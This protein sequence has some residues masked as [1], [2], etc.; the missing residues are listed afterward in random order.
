MGHIL[1]V[2]PVFKE[3]IWGG[4]QL[5]EKYGY[6]I[7]SDQTGEC[8]APSAHPNGDNTIK[9]GEFKG[10]TLSK[11]FD[12]HREL[13]GNIKDKQFPLLVKI[14]DA[15]NDLS[16]QVHPNDEYAAVHENGSLG[17]TECWYI[18]DCKEDANI[19]IGHHAKDKKELADM[20]HE[21]RWNELIRTIPIKGKGI[22]SRLIQVVFMLLKVEH[23]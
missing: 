19:V 17:K 9:E 7:P 2:E 23:F 22:S 21:G 14:I 3:M 1:W 8:W 12:E 15:C 16:V 20:I 11:V 18:L 5:K 4:N 6:A 10:Q 13:F